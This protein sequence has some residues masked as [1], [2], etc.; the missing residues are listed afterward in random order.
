[1]KIWLAEHTFYCGSNHKIPRI[2]YKGESMVDLIG[3]AEH[4]AREKHEGQ[5]RKGIA[6]VYMLF[7]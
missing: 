4:F 7:I 3:H 5:F 2:I 6:K 1:M